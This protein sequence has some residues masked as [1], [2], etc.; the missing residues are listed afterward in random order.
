[1]L[2]IP[3]EIPLLTTLPNP[4]LRPVYAVHLDQG[5]S[6]DNSTTIV[7][8]T[9]D[10]DQAYAYVAHQQAVLASILL[11]YKDLAPALDAWIAANPLS[12][13]LPGQSYADYYHVHGKWTVDFA[14]YKRDWLTAHLTLE[15]LTME[16]TRDNNSWCV[17]ALRW[18]PGAK[19]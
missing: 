11:K 17:Q 19:L 16:S 8:I 13:Q 14:G 3:S 6:V 4:D 12:H 9:H 1:M 15:E 5:D 7:G 18:L 2:Q 10:R